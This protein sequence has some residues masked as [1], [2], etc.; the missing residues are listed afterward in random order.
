MNPNSRQTIHL[1]INFVFAPFASI[2]RRSFIAFQNAL[3][4]ECIEVKNATI[5]DQEITIVRD[6]PTGLQVRVIALGAP[7]IGQMLIV[8][9]N[10]SPPLNVFT[11]EVVGI[12]KSF[13]ATW[14]NPNRQ[15][16]SSDA[17]IRALFETESSH[18]FQEIW[19]RRLKQTQQSLGVFGRPVLGGGLRFVMPPVQGEAKPVQ[20]EVKIE[21]FLQNSKKV[22]VDTQHTWPLPMPPG[23]KFEPELRLKQVDD[24]L[25]NQVLSFIQ[26]R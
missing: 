19:E 5:R 10:P 18:A 14:P 8:A 26:E 12:C 21:S 24:Y 3:A 9:S 13:D 23:T 7:G 25:G 22:F 2:D 20:I 1:G 6:T 16:I 15:L 17:T 11:E 4:E